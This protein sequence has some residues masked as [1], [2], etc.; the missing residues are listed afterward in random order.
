MGCSW[1]FMM[2]SRKRRFPST[3][4][5]ASFFSIYKE[6][7]DSEMEENKTKDD[8]S[9][10]R[11]FMK[12][13]TWWLNNRSWLK[14]DSGMGML[15]ELCIR[16]GKQ[17]PFTKFYYGSYIH[18]FMH[19]SCQMNCFIPLVHRCIFSFCSFQFIGPFPKKYGP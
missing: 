14:H 17:P 16:L 2:A 11:K 7:V 15:C 10:E 3:R 1:I 13:C 6:T 8:D 4:S 5:I 12:Y 9:C 19:I 18:H